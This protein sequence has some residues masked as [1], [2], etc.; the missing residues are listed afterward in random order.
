MGPGRDSA[1]C[2]LSP[3]PLVPAARAGIERGI[4]PGDDPQGSWGFCLLH[5]LLSPELLKPRSTEEAFKYLLCWLS[6]GR[7][8]QAWLCRQWGV[9]G[10]EI[11]PL[12]IPMQDWGLSRGENAVCPPS[13]PVPGVEPWQ[14]SCRGASLAEQAGVPVAGGTRYSRPLLPLQV[15]SQMPRS[16]S[17]C[18]LCTRCWP[19]RS[20]R[21]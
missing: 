19:R 20:R 5:P 16:P 21:R 11:K 14:W 15:S 7:R 1:H 18:S 10:A 13:L 3:R 9:R 8:S 2:L 12:G 6:W 4:L 17:T